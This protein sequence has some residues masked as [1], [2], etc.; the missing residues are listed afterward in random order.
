MKKKLAYTYVIAKITVILI[1][2][3]C[4]SSK[5]V[6]QPGN[7]FSLADSSKAFTQKRVTDFKI[8]G[9]RSG[10]FF[11]GPDSIVLKLI[12]NPN[13]KKSSYITEDGKII[14]VETGAPPTVIIP[15]YWPGQSLDNEDNG[16]GVRI[17]YEG[18]DSLYLRY[19]KIKDNDSSYHLAGTVPIEKGN[20]FKL[21]I[22]YN[23]NWYR[24]ESGV[25]VPLYYWEHIEKPDGPKRIAEGRLIMN[26]PKQQP[27]GTKK[28]TNKVYYYYNTKK[29]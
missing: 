24:I 9:F 6:A 21:K 14:L 18:N 29:Q 23:N 10:Q 22:W 3:S 16:A 15:A 19:A 11:N 8:T 20:T 1:A 12:E 17:T 7:A 25:N 4:T 27:S 2:A 13:D 28:G 5:K 26:K